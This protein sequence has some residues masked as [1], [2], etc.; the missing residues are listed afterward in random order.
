MNLTPQ[1]L[2]TFCFL[3]VFWER[4]SEIQAHWDFQ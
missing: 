4:N 3:F 1:S 2:A